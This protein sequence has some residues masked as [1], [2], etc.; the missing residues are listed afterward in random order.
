MGERNSHEIHV[1]LTNGTKVHFTR[2]EIQSFLLTPRVLAFQLIVLLLLA[3]VNPTLFPA[4]PDYT[5][6]IFYWGL[7]IVIYLLLAPLW[8]EI[9][10][11]AWSRLSSKP[12]PHILSSVPFLLLLTGFTHYLEHLL[13]GFLPPV[14]G[15]LTWIVI[16]QNL[17]IGHAFEL[18]GAVLLYPYLRAA[19]DPVEQ[20]DATS[21][22]RFV[23]FNGQSIPLWSIKTVK[24][25]EHHLIVT[26]EHKT[27]EYRAKLKDFL[28][29]IDT[30]HGIQ[31]HRSYWVAADEALELH[32][33]AVRTKS[34][35]SVPVARGRLPMV[36]E[37]FRNQEKPH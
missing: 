12:L 20:M 29:Q 4:L 5:S 33:L 36:R 28:G 23:V 35:E 2:R 14:H 26:T 19:H 25:A 15:P 37:W 16:A 24:S 34:G 32:G 13:S 27:A 31:T 9:I 8:V 21:E 17:V 18:I 30:H 7:C 6:R 10:Y 1:L 22:P 3:V 11:S